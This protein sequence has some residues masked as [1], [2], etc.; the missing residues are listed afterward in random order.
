MGSPFKIWHVNRLEPMVVAWINLETLKFFLI[1]NLKK[2][3][4]N[5]DDRDTQETRYPPL[6]P[7]KLPGLPE[8]CLSRYQLHFKDTG[9]DGIMNQVTQE[10]DWK[11]I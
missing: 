7:A 8:Y 10:S 1:W 3:S 5:S 4:F 11:N 2:D 6:T 9:K